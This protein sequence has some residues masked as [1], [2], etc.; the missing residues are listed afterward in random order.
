VLFRDRLVGTLRAVEPILDVPGVMVVGSEVP[1]LLQRDAAS[2]LVISQDVDLGVPIGVHAEVVERLARIVDLVPSPDEPSVWVP[3]PEH[4]ERLIEVNFLG[5]DRSKID[6][7][8]V[9]VLQDERLPLMVFPALSLLRAGAPLVIDGV[10]VPVPRPAGLALEKLSTD[11]S[12][13]KGDRDLLVVIGLL[14]SMSPA[15]R[16]ELIVEY[17]RLSP[18]LKHQIRTSLTVASLLEARPGMPDPAPQRAAL[19]SLLEMLEEP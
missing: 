6:P 17:G 15:D 14:E 2:T 10:R 11:R 5:V 9:Y 1:N 13:D 18:E 7:V 16:D 8:D 4:A 12:G 19:A 3:R